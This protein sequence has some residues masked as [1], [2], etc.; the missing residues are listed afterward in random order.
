MVAGIRC[1]SIWTTSNGKGSHNTTQHKQHPLSAV[2]TKPGI[3]NSHDKMKKT[4]RLTGLKL[5]A[6]VIQMLDAK[7]SISLWTRW[8][9]SETV[10][11]K[12]I[13]TEDNILIMCK[14]ARW[15]TE[16]S[17]LNSILTD[18]KQSR[19]APGFLPECFLNSSW[20]RRVQL[21]FSWLCKTLWDAFWKWYS[22]F[23]N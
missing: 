17:S 8:G 16:I 13:Y 23:T 4:P 9:W 7:T 19:S 6:A 22:T 21:F 11:K 20:L 15:I 5:E 2:G 18:S 14:V 1:W 10:S 3:L 12:K